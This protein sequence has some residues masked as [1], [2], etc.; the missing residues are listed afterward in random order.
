MTVI[1][2]RAGFMAAQMGKGFMMGAD[3]E[4]GRQA[5]EGRGILMS[6]QEG[7]GEPVAELCKGVRKRGGDEL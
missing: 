7:A 4:G 6:A 1:K 2:L 3:S 5:K